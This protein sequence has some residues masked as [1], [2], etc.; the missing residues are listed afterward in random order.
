M[1]WWPRLPPVDKLYYAAL[2]AQCEALR[3]ALAQA[4]AERDMLRFH[5]GT[6]ESF[7]HSPAALR[8]YCKETMRLD[9]WRPPNPKAEAVVRAAKAWDAWVNPDRKPRKPTFQKCTDDLRRAVA[10]LI[11]SEKKGR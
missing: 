9:G 4:E 3:K 8:A 1:L 6:C 7:K 5:V 2:E 10:A 11:K